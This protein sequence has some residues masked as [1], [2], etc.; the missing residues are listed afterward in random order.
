M[1]KENWDGP[2]QDEERCRECGETEQ[3]GKQQRRM[4]I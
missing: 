2:D 3:K 1:V 4:G